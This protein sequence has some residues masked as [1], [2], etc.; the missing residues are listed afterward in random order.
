VFFA[1][2]TDQL[3]DIPKKLNILNSMSKFFPAGLL[4]VA[5]N[6]TP[7]DLWVGHREGMCPISG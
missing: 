6:G 3:F 2:L 5:I 4:Q 1:V 7:Q